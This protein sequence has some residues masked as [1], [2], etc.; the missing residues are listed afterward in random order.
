MGGHKRVEKREEWIGGWIERVEE[1][2]FFFFFVARFLLA[3][4]TH[5]VAELS[6]PL[7]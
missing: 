2:N 6:F 3:H 1:E 5:I 4:L 7:G